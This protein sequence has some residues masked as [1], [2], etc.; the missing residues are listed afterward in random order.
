MANRLEGVAGQ[1]WLF[2]E[3]I[4][5]I[6]RKCLFTVRTRFRVIAEDG[7]MK[8]FFV[9]LYQRAK[10]GATIPTSKHQLSHSFAMTKISYFNI[11]LYSDRAI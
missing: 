9:H 7:R 11:K 3:I 1:K 8:G 4:K 6:V 10:F 2:E 5:L